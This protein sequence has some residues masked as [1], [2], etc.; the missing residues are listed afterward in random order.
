MTTP[1]ASWPVCTITTP[2]PWAITQYK[3]GN[4]MPKGRNLGWIPGA[5]NK[6]SH[7]RDEIK[8]LL[9]TGLHAKR[10]QSQLIVNGLSAISSIADWTVSNA[11]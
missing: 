5:H 10:G 8:F 2:I 11:L 3:R 7:S 1:Q 4:V 6:V 9:K